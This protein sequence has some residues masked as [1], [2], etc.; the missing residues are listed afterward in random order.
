[1]YI[2]IIRAFKRLKQEMMPETVEERESGDLGELFGVAKGQGA[3]GIRSIRPSTVRRPG[4][5][6]T[7]I[8]I[9]SQAL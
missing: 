4:F 7:G 6:S 2:E 3:R 5:V 8:K 9:H 1:M